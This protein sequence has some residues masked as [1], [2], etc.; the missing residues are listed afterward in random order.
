MGKKIKVGIFYQ[1]NENWIGGTYYIE[2]LL[3][4][5][6]R[7]NSIDA[8]DV[9]IIINNKESLQR[10]KSL[11]FL[12]FFNYILIQ[13]NILERIVNKASRIFFKKN[14]IQKRINLD[15]VFPASEDVKEIQAVKNLLFWI[16]DFQEHYLPHLFSKNEIDARKAYHELIVERKYPIIFSSL[17]SEQDF[18]EIYKTA[19]NPTFVL[20]FAVF[21]K[22]L[23]PE[24]NHLLDKFNVN[25][26]YLMAPNQFWQHKNHEIL[27]EAFNE[28]K[29]R[30]INL[31]LVLTGKDYDHRNPNYTAEL[32][33]KAIN[34]GLTNIHF[35]GL[36][37]REEQLT[38]LNNAYAVIQPSLF[39]GWSTV[40]EDA[41]ALNKTIIASDLPVHREQLENNAYF[42]NPNNYMELADIIVEIVSSKDILKYN[43]NYSTNQLEFSK[44]F[45]QIIHNIINR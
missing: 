10:I 12:N 42:F 35:L 45:I 21:H 8:L 14:I 27:L 44:K 39:E 15:I 19:K 1:Y 31:D 33:Q 38:L 25:K 32:K 23:K 3:Q 43:Q 41:K 16:P 5:I 22:P 40:I 26:M 34:Y 17:A 24:I 13:Y 4:S 29:K 11:G 6:V 36:I 28:L 30:Q 9:F 20:P 18:F 2:N 7:S 37:D